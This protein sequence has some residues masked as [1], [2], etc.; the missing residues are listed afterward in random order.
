MTRNRPAPTTRAEASLAAIE[1]RLEEAI[2]ATL[3]RRARPLRLRDVLLEVIGAVMS[4]GA[5]GAVVGLSGRGSAEVF[6]LVLALP[7]AMASGMLLERAASE[8]LGSPRERAA[9][10][11]AEGDG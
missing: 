7:F 9:R 6:A 4:A 5:A 10:H 1:D 11:R 8:V 2:A 3:A